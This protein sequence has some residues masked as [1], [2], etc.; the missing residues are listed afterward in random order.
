MN[1]YLNNQIIGSTT[2]D[3]SKFTSGEFRHTINLNNLGYHIGDMHIV[4][5]VPPKSTYKKYSKELKLPAIL[6]NINKNNNL[7]SILDDEFM[8]LNDGLDKNDKFK[9][10]ENNQFNDELE[11]DH[12][13]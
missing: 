4:C 12:D 11:F 3:P 7:N 1:V 5:N 8:E 2:F 6:D 9:L 10:Y 13:L